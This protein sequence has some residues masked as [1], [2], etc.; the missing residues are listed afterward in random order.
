MLEVAILGSGSTGNA[1]LVGD[2]ET[3]LLVDAGL[4]VRELER[5]LSAVGH[6]PKGLAAVLVTHEHRDHAGGAGKFCTRHRLPVHLTALTRSVSGMASVEGRTFESGARFT[7]GTLEVHTVPIPHLAAD[8]VAFI[9]RSNG[10]GAGILT[11]LGCLTPRVRQA[12]RGLE[13]LVLEANH[14]PE[15]LRLGSYPEFLKRSIASN[16]GHLSNLQAASAAVDLVTERTQCVY[17]AHLSEEN[18]RPELALRTV[19]RALES[20]LYSPE[21]AALPAHEPTGPVT[22]R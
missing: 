22:L 11:D 3:W 12:F 19:G 1:A 13:L 18:N 6:S 7:V 4:G 20:R 9:V 21:L 10:K 14:D 17:L 16:I 5:R 8:P 2:G 15:L